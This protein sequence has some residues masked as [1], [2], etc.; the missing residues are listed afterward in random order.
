MIHRVR[1]VLRLAARDLRGGL[2]GLRV[3]LAC[4]T[5]GVAA[6]TGVGSVANSLLGS[7]ATQGS[8]MLGGDL[9]FSRSQRPLNGQERAWLADQ[10]RL[11]EIA[12]MRATARTT[13][14]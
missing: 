10:G 12:T 13:T 7:I 5:I 8:V 11:S 1:L 4:V 6:I 3:F 2:R 14:D 9:A